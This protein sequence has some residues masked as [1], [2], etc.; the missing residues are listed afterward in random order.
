MQLTDEQQK[1]IDMVKDD[2]TKLLKINSVAGSGKTSILIEIV[3]SIE[4]K[5]GLY[6]AYNKSIA[7]EAS[8]KFP[9]TVKCSTVHSLAFRNTVSELNYD[10]GF[11]NWKSINKPIDYEY[12]IIIIDLMNDFFLSK[13]T[14][15]NDFIESDQYKK[16]QMNFVHKD[17]I[18]YT[19][20][21]VRKMLT[22]KIDITHAGYLKLYHILLENEKIQHKEFDFVMIDEAG[23]INEVILEIFNLLPA[24]KKIM[25]GDENQNIY[26]FNN[27]ING[28]NVM[29]NQGV[30][31]NMTQSFR[32]D[33]KIAKKIESFM[34]KYL[35]PNFSFVG[36]DIKDENINSIMI[37]SRTNSA[38]IEQMIELRMVGIDFSLTRKSSVIFELIMILLNLGP[39]STIYSKEWK[40][41][42]DDAIEY[43]DNP[44]LKEDY[45]S[46]FGYLIA[47]YKNDIAIKTAIGT[48]LKYGRDDIYSVYNYAK[49]NDSKR[50]KY[51]YI[52]TTCHSSKGL[53]ADY[54]I[55]T[56]DMNLSIEKIIEKDK[57][58]YSEKEI[59]AL[60]L[61]YVGA[62]RAI[63]KLENAIYL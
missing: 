23:D 60:M 48:I 35:N 62:S 24:K 32:C 27:T 28:F 8:K 30:Q 26:T 25:V 16:E 47:K 59:E 3:K 5:N 63:K 9:N 41:L 56:D 7:T 34:K 43:N 61:Y 17:I 37:I 21:Y 6:L 33:T 10:I 15:F 52:L 22:G 45:S 49:V 29:K 46:L 40:F 4:H 58:E 20:E 57:N 38:L 19:E 36:S 13:Y 44:F 31:L 12:K 1:I 50:K 39:K 11:F 18:K 51:K 55:F 42:K 54:V 2:N 53:E 14:K